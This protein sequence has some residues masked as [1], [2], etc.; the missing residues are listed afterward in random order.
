MKLKTTLARTAT[1]F[2]LGSLTL[3]TVGLGVIPDAHAQIQIRMETNALVIT[4]GAKNADLL[5]ADDVTG[6][7]T[8]ITGAS[9]PYRI[10]RLASKRFYQL[11]I[12]RQ[13]DGAR[14]Q[15]PAPLPGVQAAVSRF[16]L[17]DP[18]ATFSFFNGHVDNFATRPKSKVPGYAV[19]VLTSL[20]LSTESKE[21]VLLASP[22][23]DPKPAHDQDAN[24]DLALSTV[25]EL[26][27]GERPESKGDDD[28]HDPPTGD[29]PPE[30]RRTRPNPDAQTLVPWTRPTAT[31]LALENRAA[32][33][34][35]LNF[36]L[37][38]PEV[39]EVGRDEFST[40]LAQV[41]YKVGAFFRKATFTQ[42]YA[43]GKPVVDGRTLVFF[44]AN[45]NV[46]TISRMI[47]TP[48]KLPIEPLTS[49]S[50]SETQA[51]ITA[52]AQALGRECAG[53]DLRVL[54]A[55]LGVDHIRR[56]H[57]WDVE[58]E[59]VDSECHW[60]TTLHAN[61][62]AVLNVSDQR[63][64]GYVD[65]KLRRWRY[66][67]GNNFNPQQFISTGQYTRSDRRLEHD[68]FWVMNDHRC[69]GAAE[70]TCTN[71]VFSSV[72]CNLAHGTNNGAS[73]I[74]ATVRT[75]RDWTGWY[76]SSS[77]ET[78]AETHTYYWARQFCQWLK[79][80]LDAL[81]VLPDSAADY[82]KVLI[83]TDM[84]RSRAR[85][86]GNGYQVT[87]EG[88]KG[89]G[90]RA[91]LIPHR[92]P[93]GPEVHN[94]TCE[95][96]ACFDTPGN[97]AH[98]LNHF[99]LAAYFGVSSG[100]DC[101]KALEGGATHEGILGTAVPQ[102]FWHHY[103]GV[104]Y[105]PP[106]DNLYFSDAT[107]G[108]VHDDEASRMIYENYDCDWSVTNEDPYT[109][110]RVAGQVMWEI[111][112]GKKINNNGTISGMGR[113]GTDTFFNIICY[114]AADLQAASTFPDRYE[115]ANRVLEILDKA[116]WTQATRQ[117]YYQ[118]FTHHSLH[119]NIDTDYID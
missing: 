31:T 113:P 33:P 90:G 114:W 2:A 73:S 42:R 17:S 72:A 40:A 93:A 89:E 119:W 67:G 117:N 22:T 65:A 52:K 66:P 50:I 108:L 1:R 64:F 110:G 85:A 53:T 116:G 43:N 45:W 78:F 49:T 71:T 82:T 12:L 107:V 16:K 19:S 79:P 47:T 96:G 104:G 70:T 55:D 69:D 112:H 10:S 80:A 37:E 14:T 75:D 21:P 39:F 44:D 51:V 15:N 58:L 25:P 23:L 100:T 18:D 111:Y 102:A 48:A 88:N 63:Q 26:D 28:A 3:A 95:G 5:E 7:W 74:R 81:G 99:F 94:D 35:L 91:I 13:P 76:P 59:S 68:F 77:S 32:T 60:R 36:L 87:T 61:S 46:I 83:I 56:T 103:Y 109:A 84:C 24:L 30:D 41:D 97:I 9:S 106:T 98:E 115:Y 62:G 118:A 4:W 105:N 92:N 8:P 11:Q 38:H 6:P 20:G 27:D 29:R 54:R 101:S 34:I 86:T 57:V